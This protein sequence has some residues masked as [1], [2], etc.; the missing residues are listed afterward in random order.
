[1]IDFSR[2][3][4]NDDFVVITE[5]AQRDLEAIADTKYYG[6][7]YPPLLKKG[8]FGWMWKKFCC[9]RNMHLFDEVVTATE[10][11]VPGH[12]LNCDCCELVVEIGRV[13]TSDEVTEKINKF[14]DDLIDKIEENKKKKGED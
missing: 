7:T 2:G 8:L 1:M 12:Y 9:P 5:R 14:Y 13:M 10:G 4:L 3:N 11:G 6:L